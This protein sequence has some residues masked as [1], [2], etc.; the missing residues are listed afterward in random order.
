MDSG[1]S[2]SWVAA[3]GGKS[4]PWLSA[5]GAPAPKR[6]ILVD[7]TITADAAYRSASQGV[8]LLWNGDY[9]GARQILTALE[10][11]TR[12]KPDTTTR[13]M[14]E[15]FYRYR[16]NRSH[17]ARIL[18]MILVPLGAGNAI[19][20]RRAPDVRDASLAAYGRVDATSAVSLQEIVGAIG[21]QQWR[22]KGIPVAALGASVHPHYGTFFP[23][24]SEY[25]DLVAAEPL[26][27]MATAVVLTR[28]SGTRPVQAGLMRTAPVRTAFDIG[29]GTGVLAAVLAR[30]GVERVVATDIEPRAV[31]SARDTV[32]LLGFADRVEVVLADL[33]PD[34]QADLIVCNPPWIPAMAHSLL[35]AAVY[36]PGSRMLRG[37]LEGAVAHLSPGGEVW[38]VLSD[39]AELVGL[40]T[41]EDLLALIASAGLQVVGSR[42]VPAV[43]A[44]AADV[45]DPL[46]AVR[47]AEVTTLWR[48]AVA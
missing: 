5:N 2:I 24:R 11:R 20:L 44:R 9:H 6:V 30:R 17:R 34:G 40:R 47:A 37:F 45:T 4:L 39:F 13:P 12:P 48:L 31:A 21:A 7:D 25:V 42:A 38:L 8:A 19:E 43:H 26:G 32:L 18:S 46:H 41:R 27:S 36:D 23:V 14:S 16:Q 1:S 35:D 33:F 28:T 29:T 15:L 3:E 22:A 10:H